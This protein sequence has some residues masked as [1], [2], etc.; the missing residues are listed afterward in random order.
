[1]FVYIC[2]WWSIYIWKSKVDIE[3]LLCLLNII[4]RSGSLSELSK[5]SWPETSKDSPVS[6]FSVMGYSHIICT[7]GLEI[8]KSCFHFKYFTDW[9]IVSVCSPTVLKPSSEHLSAGSQGSLL[10]CYWRIIFNC[11]DCLNSR[12]HGLQN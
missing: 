12:N 11:R 2:V 8:E 4:L 3:Y 1:M 9:A 5:T 10:L 7:W 6:T